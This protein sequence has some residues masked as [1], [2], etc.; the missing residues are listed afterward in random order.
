MSGWGGKREGAGR[1]LIGG[2]PRKPRQVRATD[3]E[4]ATIKEFVRLVKAKPKTA[5]K[6]LKQF[7]E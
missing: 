7:G 2:V 4:W 6:L 3:D 1:P 5:R